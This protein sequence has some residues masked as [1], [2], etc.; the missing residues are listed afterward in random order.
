MADGLMRDVNG[1][2]SS[3]RVA[4]YVLMSASLLAGFVGAV[5]GNTV[6]V[7]YSKWVLTTG[8]ASVI[9]GVAERR[10]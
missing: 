7:D 9:A 4:G 6:L 8:A 1:N 10:S 3:K 2:L 5:L